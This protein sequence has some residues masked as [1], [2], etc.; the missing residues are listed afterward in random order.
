MKKIRR[1]RVGSITFGV[2][3]LLYG[4]LFLTHTF[5]TSIDYQ[6]IF[7]LWPLTF[8]LLGAEVLIS[9]KKE[10]DRFIYDKAAIFLLIILTL[11]AVMMAGA[12]CLMQD[13]EFWRGR[14]VRF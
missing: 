5:V 10:Q 14:Y 6:F 12:D 7:R 9:T 13:Y 3:L 1:H 11:F 2:M 4:V 8:I